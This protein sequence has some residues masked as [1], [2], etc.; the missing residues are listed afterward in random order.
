VT[1]YAPQGKLRWKFT[2]PMIAIWI[3]LLVL[4]W[5]P[6][7]FPELPIPYVNFIFRVA[8]SNPN[9][10]K[11]LVTVAGFIGVLGLVSWTIWG[12]EP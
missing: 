11:I 9:P 2:A 5:I 12:D 6:T 3:G 1:V 8:S 10:V 4:I 7:E